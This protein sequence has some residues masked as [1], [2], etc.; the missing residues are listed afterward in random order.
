[1]SRWIWAVWLC[2][3]FVL[4]QGCNCEDTIERDDPMSI[5]ILA[6]TGTVVSQGLVRAEVEDFNGIQHVSIFIDGKEIAKKDAANKQK[7]TIEVQFDLDKQPEQFEIKIVGVDVTQEEASKRITVRK[8]QEVPQLRFTKPEKLDPKHEKI[9]VGKTFEAVVEARDTGGIKEVVVSLVYDAKNEETVKT[10]AINGSSPSWETCKAT[11]NLSDPKYK[12]GDLILQATA[13]NNKGRSPDRKSRLQVVLDKTGPTIQITSPKADQRLKGEETFLALIRDQ[14]GVKRVEMLIDQTQLTVKTDGDKF[15]AT[16]P[17][18]VIKGNA[19]V[20]KV[21]AYDNLGN[22][23]EATLKVRGG[24]TSDADCDAGMRCCVANSPKNEKGEFT[25]RCFKIQDT[26]GSLCDPCT[27]PCGKGT[28]GKLMGCLPGACERPPHR[29]RRACNLGNRNQRPDPCRKADPA[30]N[31]PAE[32]CAPSDVTRIN[33]SLGSCA[34]G[35]NCDPINQTTCQGNPNPPYNGC[36]PKGFGCYPADDD[37]NICIPEGSTQ[38]RG[39]NCELHNCQGGRNC[40]KGHLCTVRTDAQGRPVGASSCNPM[41]V[42]NS[43]CQAGLPTACPGGGFCSPVR[44]TN[45]NVPLPMGVCV[46]P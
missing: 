12:D 31:Q 40:T 1:M 22:K 23:S 32:Y 37:A 44:L 26:E 29:C 10:C 17:K 43:I 21:I 34:Q 39:T 16:I 27:Q 19:P 45:G 11:L 8:E 9:F 46:N 13:T 38:P 24:C 28:D 18:S 41:C 14:V 25:G 30:T 20:L 33:S 6:P 2:F 5:K 3:A 7:Y 15:S 35:D 42:C 4:S 36:C